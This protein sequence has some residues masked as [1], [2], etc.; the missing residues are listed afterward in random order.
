[1]I[2]LLVFASLFAGS[3]SIDKRGPVLRD[4]V[5]ICRVDNENLMVTSC[6]PI[7]QFMIDDMYE[8]TDYMLEEDPKNKKMAVRMLTSRGPLKFVIKTKVVGSQG[9][10]RKHVITVPNPSEKR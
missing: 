2:Y 6:D 3:P 5:K 8:N 1:M 7:E 4:V 10:L 9:L